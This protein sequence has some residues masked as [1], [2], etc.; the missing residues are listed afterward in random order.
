MLNFKVIRNERPIRFR[1]PRALIKLGIWL[2]AIV[3][4]ILFATFGVKLLADY[5][6]MDNLGYGSVFTTIYTAKIS[7]WGIGF[8]LFSACTYSLFVN[9]RATYMRE[10]PNETFISLIT[11]RKRF[12]R[13]NIALSLLVGL[14]GSF[15]VQGLGWEPFLTFLNQA[16]FNV[17][18]PYFGR[19]VSFFVYTLPMWK[20]AL[21]VFLFI[22]GGSIVVKL[23]FYSLRGLILH[24]NRAQRHFLVSIGLLGLLIA[25][26]FALAP[27]D[28]ALTKSVS[29]LKDSVVYGI[30][31]TDNLINIP[32]NYIMAA[33]AIVTAALIIVAI[34]KRRVRFAVIGAA[35]F[36]GTSLLGGVAS[37]AVQSFIVSPNEYAK[38]KPYLQHN[39][40]YTRKAYGLDE[41]KVTS[42][43]VNDSLSKKMLARND[44]TVKNIRI[45]DSRPLE[46]VYNQLQTFRPYYDFLDVDVDRYVI[47]GEYR[48]VF[49]S[50][51][52]L[53]Q[54]KLP[55]QAQT[56]VNK[57]LRYTHGY[58]I[59]MSNVNEV[60]KEGQPKYVVKDLPP[61]GPL[62]IKRPQIYFGEND[63]RTV[64]VNTAVDEFDYPSS[65][66][67][68][69]HRYEMNSGIPMTMLNRVLFAWNE[70]NFRYLVSEQITKESKL[71]Q[72]RNIVDRVKRIAPFLD[73]GED[74]YPV[75]RDDGSIVWLLDAYTKTNRYPYADSMEKPYNY[76]KNPIKIAV[77]AYTGEVTFYLVDPDEPIAKTYQNMFPRLFT[78]DIPEDI[79][80]HF[81][82]PFDL[83]KIEADVYRVYHMTNLELFYNREDMWQFPTEKYGDKDIEMEPYYVTMKLDDSERE[84]F[85]M[86]IPFTPNTKQNMIAWM[87]VR[88]DGDRYGDMVVYEYTKQRNIYGPQQIEN[89]INQ[90]ATISQQLNLWSQGGSR[91]IRGNLL[92]IPIEDTLLYV[93]PLYIESSNETSLPEVKQVI[94]AY[95]DYI[96]MEPTLGEAIE[97]LVSY[98]DAGVDP[99]ELDEATGDS[100]K[101]DKDGDNSDEEDSKESDKAKGKDSQQKD[102]PRAL[103]Q[104]PDELVKDIQST[105]NRYR[106]ANKDGN[107]EEAGR[108]L[109]QLEEL[110][111]KWEQQNKPP[112][113]PQKSDK[114]P[115]EKGQD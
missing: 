5:V 106:Q 56:W 1:P 76:I 83:F 10:F 33:L 13:L 42:K 29:G 39:L 40:D 67:N 63:Y 44:L 111:E 55:D 37:W 91:V 115:S 34:V 79:R 12:F 89:R 51:R 11:D 8:V 69:S 24:S 18:D 104:T 35:L 85:I 30:S 3:A 64:V 98:V 75:V 36:I 54:N 66:E 9:I 113:E 94:V 49:I 71:L 6:W 21:S 81:R 114:K 100:G 88:N 68:K 72:T 65:N 95:Q 109:K 70:G 28:K 101:A 23:V 108:A 31:Y 87:A 41:V 62:D 32:L 84:E 19:D 93:E 74:P 15:V 20:F 50:A 52:E 86:L 107:Y 105:F 43:E 73:L 26:Q 46:N 2:S 25:C 38:E 77:D 27:Y 48:Q 59:S 47:D 112:T 99:S 58:G 96:V 4:V 7:L 78:T 22:V 61:Q 16:S 14:L 57:N 97:K 80:S 92:V 102:D 45:N 60:T 82:Y 90:D 17:T 53:R 103:P 110:L